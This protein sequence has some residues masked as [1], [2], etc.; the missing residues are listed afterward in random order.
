MKLLLWAC[1]IE[2]ILHFT[3]NKFAADFGEML[4][5]IF[6]TSI[7]LVSAAILFLL[8]TKIRQEVMLILGFLKK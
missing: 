2:W 1:F 6:N 8:D 4:F 3:T 5:A 7:I